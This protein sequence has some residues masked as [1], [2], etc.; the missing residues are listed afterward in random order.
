[1][2][3]LSPGE[4]TDL[5][6]MR[7]QLAKARL[8]KARNTTGDIFSILGQ[9]P[10]TRP[11]PEPGVQRDFSPQQEIALR[12]K[13][14]GLMDQRKAA[15]DRV[16]RAGQSKT[17]AA[18]VGSGFDYKLLKI[19][20]DARY[21]AREK[22]AA[23]L[24]TANTQALGNADQV[25]L[26]TVGKGTVFPSDAN[27]AA[28]RKYLDTPERYAVGEG[29][30]TALEE[31]LRKHPKPADKL[32]IIS[33]LDTSFDGQLEAKLRESAERGSHVAQQVLATVEGAK[34]QRDD[35]LAAKNVTY[36]QSNDALISAIGRDD[37]KLKE[38]M[39]EF[40]EAMGTG[41]T[42]GAAAKI[43][44]QIAQSASQPAPTAGGDTGG[45][46][47]YQE[48]LDKLSDDANQSQPE[49]IQGRHQ[50]FGDERFKK[51]M[52]SYGYSDPR[53]A[54]K[55]LSKIWRKERRD[56][57]KETRA[58]MS[59]DARKGFIPGMD[60]SETI[61][62]TEEEVAEETAAS[63]PSA[64]ARLADGG[65]GASAPDTTTPPSSK[66]LH[67]Q[68]YKPTLYGTKAAPR[69]LWLKYNEKPVEFDPLATLDWFQENDLRA[70]Y[71]PDVTP[72]SLD[73][74]WEGVQPDFEEPYPIQPERADA[75]GKMAPPPVGQTEVA[76]VP[77]TQQIATLAKGD[78][79]LGH[80]PR[81]GVPAPPPIVDT[82]LA[83]TGANPPD[84]LASQRR[85]GATAL[86]NLWGDETPPGGW[87]T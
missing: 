62:P 81:T 61:E 29:A 44:T 63:K 26:D 36:N 17:V 19:Y 14:Q 73:S 4:E 83:I 6:S 71:R 69:G 45:K 78:P 55:A 3:E 56:N 23:V 66:E 82:T 30:F 86:K 53:L 49:V 72:P 48:V 5:L 47:Q 50:L 18:S 46:D 2:A 9:R 22:A 25:Y 64:A 35:A 15:L 79:P 11:A 20:V 59:K 37:Y 32:A 80:D 16:R 52:D 40:R 74:P 10:P 8:R 67:D 84:S 87:V 70:E 54:L 7:S 68:G 21:G 39:A 27:I 31:D 76:Q 51:F 38:V 75:W 41:D 1:M 65:T 42:A 85:W 43:A 33:N 28:W 24:G 60:R 57:R 34:V 77:P 13:I 12:L 58:R